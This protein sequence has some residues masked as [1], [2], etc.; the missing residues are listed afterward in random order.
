MTVQEL[1]IKE[2]FDVIMEALRISSTFKDSHHFK[3]YESYGCGMGNRIENAID[4]MPVTLSEDMKN[5]ERALIYLSG[6]MMQLRFIT[7]QWKSVNAF[8][9]RF[10]LETDVMALPIDENSPTDRIRLSVILS[11]KE[12][13]L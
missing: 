5:C 2:D 1:F 11:G 7:V 8:I 6:P 3:V 13:E 9:Q 4:C 12:L 10:P